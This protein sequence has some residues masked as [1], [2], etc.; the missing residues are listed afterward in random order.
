MSSTTDKAK[1]L[2]TMIIIT[3]TSVL[4]CR[5]DPSSF[6]QELMDNIIFNME[7]WHQPY[8]GQI[9]MS[10]NGQRLTIQKADDMTDGHILRLLTFNGASDALTSND[11]EL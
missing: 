3:D 4:V 1:I 11:R 6:Y 7:N 2:E 8:N 10:S 5:S 9:Q